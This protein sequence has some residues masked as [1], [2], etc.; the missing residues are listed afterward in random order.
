MFIIFL[1]KDRLFWSKMTQCWWILCIL[2]NFWSKIDYFDHKWQNFGGFNAKFSIFILNIQSKMDKFGGAL[3]IKVWWK[4]NYFVWFILH[5]SF[6]MDTT[7]VEFC[8]NL[9]IYYICDEKRTTL[10]NLLLNYAFL[11]TFSWKW[12][13]LIENR[14]KFSIFILKMDYF[15]P[16]ILNLKF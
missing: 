7:W 5:F 15:H 16:F 13:I 9:A 10:I 4:A 6:K 2:F 12:T 8:P 1:I 14:A 11:F 3:A